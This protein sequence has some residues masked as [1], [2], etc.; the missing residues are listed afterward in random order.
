MMSLD[1]AT[2]KA[3]L[4]QQSEYAALEQYCADY[5]YYNEWRSF[6]VSEMRELFN[7]YVDE[8]SLETLVNEKR[9][10]GIIPNPTVVGSEVV[11]TG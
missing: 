7:E 4:K 2:F 3:I 5:F 10:R 9:W 11:Y 8:S 1:E 6:T